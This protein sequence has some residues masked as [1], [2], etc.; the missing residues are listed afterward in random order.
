M[1]INNFSCITIYNIEKKEPIAIFD[2]YSNANRYLFENNKNP[3]SSYR[4]IWY[5]H[6]SKKKLKTDRFDFIVC[7]RTAN[8]I[9]LKLLNDM[10]WYIYPDYPIPIEI[11]MKGFRDS[12]YS[13]WQKH[14]KE[15]M[16]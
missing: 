4:K 8:D 10:D 3:E 12:R 9:Q 7:F 6:Q 15:K 14:C 13:L 11:K 16:K 5:A 1:G 2:S